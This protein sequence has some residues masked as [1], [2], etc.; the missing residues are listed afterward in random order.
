MLSGCGI[1]KMSEDD[2]GWRLIIQNWLA[3]Q[4]DVNRE[5][6]TDLCKRYVQESIDFLKHE[7]VIRQE[8]VKNRSIVGYNHPHGK[9]QNAVSMTDSHMV[10]NLIAIFEVRS[11]LLCKSFET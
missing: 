3:R 9:L 10:Q 2:V 7:K 6:L 4:S 11:W 5:V 8:K 1:L